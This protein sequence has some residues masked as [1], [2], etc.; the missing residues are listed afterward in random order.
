[1]AAPESEIKRD[2]APAEDRGASVE[3]SEE[4]KAEVE[5]RPAVEGKKSAKRERRNGKKAQ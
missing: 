1:M 3:A 2:A 5:P 4:T